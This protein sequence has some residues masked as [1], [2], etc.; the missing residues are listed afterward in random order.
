MSTFSALALLAKIRGITNMLEIVEHE[1]SIL[2]SYKWI[3]HKI[4]TNAHADASSPIPQDTPLLHYLPGCSE[5][6]NTKEA[7]LCGD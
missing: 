4:P 3:G 2:T 6:S 7:V 5:F 1:E